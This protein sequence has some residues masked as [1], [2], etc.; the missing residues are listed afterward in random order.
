MAKAKNNGVHVQGIRRNGKPQAG[1]HVLN[2]TKGKATVAGGSLLKKDAV[3]LGR[4]LAQKLRCELVVHKLDG[5][6]HRKDSFGKDPRK[7]KG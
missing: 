1:W 7:S 3:M 5:T 6:I 2:C 4:M